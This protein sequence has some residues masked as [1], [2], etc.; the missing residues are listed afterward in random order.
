MTVGRILAAGLLVAG[1]LL[2][3]ALPAAAKDSYL[4]ASPLVL[5]LSGAGGRS[6]AFVVLRG[7]DLRA[8]RM[9]VE[10]ITT[11]IRDARPQPVGWTDAPHYRFTITRMSGR[12]YDLPWYTQPATEFAFYPTAGGSGFLLVRIGGVAPR[13]GWLEARPQVVALIGRHTRGLAPAGSGDV[14]LPPSTAPWVL[15]LATLL[16]AV[17]LA[18]T[19]FLQRR[20]LRPHP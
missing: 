16:V 11:S 15:A 5:E 1:A 12:P 4:Y 18:G 8:M 6:E 19:R 3:G 14:T 10:Q 13:T 2:A 20:A 7:D 9:L 17:A